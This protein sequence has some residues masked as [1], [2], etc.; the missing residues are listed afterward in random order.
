MKKNEIPPN[1][2]DFL[3]SGAARPGP[4]ENPS[5]KANLDMKKCHKWARIWHQTNFGTGNYL[6]SAGPKYF[7]MTEIQI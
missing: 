6:K 7:G 1:Q 3:R 5:G 4:L 2:K